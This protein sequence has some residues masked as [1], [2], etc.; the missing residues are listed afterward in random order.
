MRD[1][2]SAA[3]EEERQ[4]TTRDELRFAICKLVQHLALMH[5]ALHSLRP[6]ADKARQR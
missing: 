5:G 6:F 1:I 3:V 4:V 2:R